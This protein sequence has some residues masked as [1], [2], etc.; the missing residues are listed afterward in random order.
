[1]H[2]QFLSGI[3][4]SSL[5]SINHSPDFFIIFITQQSF[6]TLLLHILE[7]FETLDHHFTLLNYG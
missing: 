7:Y 3:Q 4:L 2:H 5:F 1:M 6:L